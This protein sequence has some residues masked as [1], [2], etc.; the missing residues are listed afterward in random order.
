MKIADFLN[1]G[2]VAVDVSL[3]SKKR[4]LEDIA[5]Q[6]ALGA[7]TVTAADIL[8]SL[9]AREKL[10]STALGHGVAIPHGRIAGITDSIGAFI[11]LR[12]PVEF[13]AHDGQPVDLIFGLIVPQHSTGQHLQHLKA[14]AEKFSDESFCAEL[15]AVNDDST[16]YALLTR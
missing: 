6:L 1:N 11:R 15:R 3:S 4:I 5:K 9:A 2:R 16:A 14:L 13:E 8:A 10:G 12:H 7:P